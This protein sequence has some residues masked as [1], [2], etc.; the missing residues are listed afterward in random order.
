M[1]AT[2]GPSIRASRFRVPRTRGA[3]SGALL[4]LLGAWAALA[5]MIGPYF[6]LAYTPAA[7]S[8][9]YWTAARGWLEVLPG[10]V[11]ILGG[12]LL[13]ASASRAVTMVGGW[14]AAAGGAWLVV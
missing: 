13:L 4:V 7:N 11:V 8:A 12:L 6:N 1:T 5:P 2:M 9:W 3:A 14:L 10:L